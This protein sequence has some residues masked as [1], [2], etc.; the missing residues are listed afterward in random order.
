MPVQKIVKGNSLKGKRVRAME[1][2]RKRKCANL[3][4]SDKKEPK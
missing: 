1:I 3:Q 4:S 2:Q